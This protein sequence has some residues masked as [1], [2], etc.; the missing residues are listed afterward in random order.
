MKNCGLRIADFKLK[1]YPLLESAIRSPQLVVSCPSLIAMPLNE[2][3][4]SGPGCAS[5]NRALLASN[6][7]AADCSGN[8]SDD[9]AF[10]L[11]MVVPVWT[12]MGKSF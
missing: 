10:L 4:S 2:V 7:R 1:S 12:A 8:A 6:Q 11:A 9:G 3:A 5:Y